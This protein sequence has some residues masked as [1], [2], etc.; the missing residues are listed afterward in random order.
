MYAYVP[1]VV[2]IVNMETRVLLGYRCWFYSH[3]TSALHNKSNKGHLRD[4]CWSCREGVVVV[5]Y[6]T[7]GKRT[8]QLLWKSIFM[9]L[10]F[11][12]S[13]TT[14]GCSDEPGLFH[15]ALVVLCEANRYD[16]LRINRR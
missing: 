4:H 7:G 5:Y 14:A 10:C 15:A 12:A 6:L 8:F 2:Q 3:T 11:W 1:H 16:G 9:E 13:E